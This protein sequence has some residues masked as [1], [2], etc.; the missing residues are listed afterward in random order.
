MSTE[1]RLPQVNSDDGVWGTIL[2]QFMSAQHYN[3]GADNPANG[4]HKTVTIRP[5][6]AVAGTAPLK[7]TTGP[8]LTTPEAG[9][10]EFLND[11][12]FFTQT[13]SLT[14]KIL[15]TYSST[16]AVGDIYYR[17]S[18]GNFANLT[19]GSTDQVLSIQS[20]L[21]AWRTP[22][23]SM[24]NF[25]GGNAFSVFGGSFQIDGGGA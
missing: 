5:G 20:G 9:A 6:S 10:I 13:T 16:G 18:S 4:S 11:R 3:T 1:Q 12:L 2:N 17:D 24:N 21:P 15:A 23:S 8:L 14:R 19:A 7:F 25:D 22:A